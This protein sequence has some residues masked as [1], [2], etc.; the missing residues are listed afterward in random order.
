MVGMWER[1]VAKRL[2]TRE[3]FSQRYLKSVVLIL[4][5][6]V[7]IVSSGSLPKT[8]CSVSVSCLFIF[9]LSIF[10]WR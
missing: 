8:S 2:E 4:V 7:T 10:Y 5:N 9:N 3:T 1:R 6:I